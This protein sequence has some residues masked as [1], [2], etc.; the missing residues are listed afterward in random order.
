MGV[1]GSCLN[2]EPRG[3]VPAI[4]WGMRRLSRSRV[5]PNG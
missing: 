1:T 5:M 4:H 3:Y 2:L